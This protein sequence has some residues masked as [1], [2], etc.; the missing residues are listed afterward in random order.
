MIQEV[1]VVEGKDDVAAV[2]AA[3]DCQ[4]ITTGGFAF[5]ESFLKSL[6]KIEAR[7]GVIILTDPDYMG[8]RIRRRLDKALDHPKHAFL[9]QDQALKKDDIGVENAS[10]EAIREAIRQARPLAQE[11]KTLYSI[12]DM[13]NLGLVGHPQSKKIRDDLCDKLGIGH[14]NGKQLV[15]RLNHFQ[16]SHEE[17]IESLKEVKSWQD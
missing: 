7:Q 5:G 14:C 6:R 1:I 8:E 13:Q 17:F 9:P 4:V 2:K 12:G 11:A 15:H 10:K 3:L 16:I